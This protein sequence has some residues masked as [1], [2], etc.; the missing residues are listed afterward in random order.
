MNRVAPHQKDMRVLTVLAF[1]AALLAV[2]G[3]SKHS[4]RTWYFI[5]DKS[6]M[7]TGTCAMEGLPEAVIARYRDGLLVLSSDSIQGEER[8]SFKSGIRHGTALAFTAEGNLYASCEHVAGMRDGNL[9][10]YDARGTL[11]S[12]EHYRSNLLWG[13]CREWHPNGSLVS[14]ITY[15][16][17]ARHGICKE[18]YNDGDLRCISQYCNGKEVNTDWLD[19]SILASRDE[20]LR[21][22]WMV[23]SAS[24]AVPLE[25]RER[26]LRLLWK[27]M[28]AGS[29]HDMLGPPKHVTKSGAELYR[30]CGS[31]CFV[32]GYS[33][34]N[35]LDRVARGRTVSDEASAFGSCEIV[36]IRCSNVADRVGSGRAIAR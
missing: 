36:P 25:K 12:Q 8:I 30:I 3:C 10:R 20:V 35:T 17:G 32:I 26:V 4:Q 2:M 6:P 24:N 15:R 34:S 16:D 28:P 23:M 5:P 1:V 7:E 14:E 21:Q 13:V 11:M 18:W 31:D 29:I 27:G 9:Y 33:G 19:S 22:W